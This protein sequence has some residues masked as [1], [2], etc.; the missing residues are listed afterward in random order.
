MFKRILWMH[1]LSPRAEA[2]ADAVRLLAKQHGAWVSLVHAT[3]AP[4]GSAVLNEEARHVVDVALERRQHDAIAALAAPREALEAAGIA[5]EVQVRDGQPVDVA[6]AL[7][8]AEQG[9]LVVMG[10][11]GVSGLDRVLLGSTAARLV[12]RMPCSALV[13]RRGLGGLQRILAPVDV[14]QPAVVAVQTAA[15][16][17]R[18]SGGAVDFL[19]V[20]EPVLDL[21]EPD[22]ALRELEALLARALGPLP[23][24]WRAISVVAESP[25]A[26]ILHTAEAYDLV[27]MGTT[28]KSGLKR[29]LLGSVAEAVVNAC[30]VS[31][32]V[33]R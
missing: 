8:A 31:V 20:V 4:V 10:A 13:A 23:A 29:L 11:T 12:R 2:A 19:A 33:A 9:E 30:P 6:E 27:V 17:A 25:A 5:A 21:A 24:G 26:G 16:L 3:G 15:A 32:L 18:Q 1:D 28:G 14:D 22:V 7:V